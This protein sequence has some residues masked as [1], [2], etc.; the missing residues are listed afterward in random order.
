MSG[1]ITILFADND[2]NF[3]NLRSKWL[4]GYGYVVIKA[5]SYDQAKSILRD[6][7]TIDLAIV[8]IRLDSDD[9]END[10][11]GLFLSRQ[12][13]D[14]KIPTLI[15]TA[16]PNYE[17]VRRAQT[18]FPDGTPAHINFLGKNEGNT[19]DNK[20]RQR[21]FLNVVKGSLRGRNVFIVHGRNPIKDSVQLFVKNLDLE[22]IVLED[23]ASAG[24]TILEKF[25][26]Y[27][28]VEFVVVIVTPDDIG[29]LRTKPID[30]AKF[31][32]R[33]NVI[34]ELGYFIGKYGRLRVAILLDESQPDSDIEL[35]SDIDG[36]VY[37]PM[38]G[39]KEWQNI[40]AREMRAAGLNI[41]LQRLI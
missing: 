19:K 14:A 15:L 29:N 36:I 27:S 13:T 33:Q 12:T 34:F 9:S 23:Q 21:I 8:D 6:N 30:Q 40:L 11:S 2:V 35:P 22:P 39:N 24:R 32:A 25:E 38:R 16:Y 41:D 20:E 28:S 4:E 31:R 1:E 37:I 3:L 10:E 18:W 5:T 7:K 17:F 26:H